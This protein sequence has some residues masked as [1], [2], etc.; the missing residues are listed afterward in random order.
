MSFPILVSVLIGT[1][2][3]NAWLKSRF[4]VK[5]LESGVRPRA[6]TVESVHTNSRRKSS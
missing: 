6:K 1:W 3:V 2:A 4:R 5:L